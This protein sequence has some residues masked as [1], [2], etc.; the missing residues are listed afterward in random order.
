V[1]SLSIYSHNV[2]YKILLY[3]VGASESVHVF[4]ALLTSFIDYQS[5]LSIC[6]SYMYFELIC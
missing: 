1:V 6:D 5:Q 2:I 4:W 3:T